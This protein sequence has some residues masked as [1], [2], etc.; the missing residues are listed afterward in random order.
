MWTGIAFEDVPRLDRDS[1]PVDQPLAGPMLI[2]EDTGTIVVEPGWTVRRMA[3]DAIVEITRDDTNEARPALDDGSS[4]RPDPVELELFHGR[5]ASIAAEMG[6]VLR[7]TAQSTNIRDR[8]DF[9]CAV[10]DAEGALVTNAPHI[11]VHLGAM[12]ETVR[13]LVQRHPRPKPGTVFATNDPAAGGSHLPDITVISPVHDERGTLSFF[14]ACRGHHADVGGS[15]PGSMPPDSTRLE[16]EGVVLRE[17][18]LV[19][20]GKWRHDELHAVLTRG[21]HPARRPA[22]LEADLRAQVA[23]N[24]RGEQRLHELITRHGNVRV[25]RYMQWIQDNAATRVEE[26]ID[27]LPDGVR[28]FEDHLDD[29]TRI[30]A[31]VTIEGRHMSIDMSGSADTHP[32]NLNAPRA[33]TVAAVIYVLRCLVGREIPL[34]S[35]CLR[36]IALRIRPGSLL[37]APAG[38]AVASGNVETS[39][40]IVDVLLG[41]LGLAAASQGTMNNLSF[42]DEAFGYYETLAGGAGATPQAAGA[43]AVHTHM[44]NTRMTDPEVLEAR[45]PVRVITNA[46]RTETGGDGLHRGGDGMVRELELLAPLRVS[47]ISERR[48]RA[49][50]GLAGGA[51]GVPGQNSLDGE[52]LPNRF[53]IAL[54]PGQRLRVETPGGGGWGT[55][56]DS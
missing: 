19:D 10:F 46:V 6:A 38:A 45:F 35:G 8:L 55:P 48:S 56:D 47:M 1:L 22:Q 25:A 53:S 41:A 16:Q 34:N 52:P 21:P 40:R 15:S 51:A 27:V 12:S 31:R 3:V 32:G 28:E 30:H 44:T 7:R 36:P 54:Q 33:V 43:S 42:G 26:A 37:D 24:R 9:S 23:A 20:E 2:L 11:P 13:A 5:F 4:V 50:F 49:P 39:Q 14:V 29:G 17:L 18:V